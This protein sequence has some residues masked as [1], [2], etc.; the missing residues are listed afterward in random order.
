MI[1]SYRAGDLITWRD[2]HGLRTPRRNEDDTFTVLDA[3]ILNYVEVLNNR[4][5]EKSFMHVSVIRRIPL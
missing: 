2:K 4:T 3:N 1:A 5:C